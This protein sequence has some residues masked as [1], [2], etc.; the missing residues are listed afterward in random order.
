MFEKLLIKHD[1]EVADHT[2]KHV[3][4]VDEVDGDRIRL[5]RSKSSIAVHHFI[6]LDQIDKV[7]DNCVRLKRSVAIPVGAF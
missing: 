3:G 1:M 5:M 7:I 2:G 6:A 4:T